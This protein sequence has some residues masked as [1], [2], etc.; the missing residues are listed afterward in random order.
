MNTQHT[1]KS[2]IDAKSGGEQSREA[3]GQHPGLRQP[4][5]DQRAGQAP[6]EAEP[7][8][9]ELDD[10]LGATVEDE[11][12]G[13]RGSGIAPVDDV[14]SDGDDDERNERR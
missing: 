11:I 14:R 12:R 8:D 2:A 13:R 7:D 6:D 3:S 4:A 10:D 9:L 5:D 1:Q